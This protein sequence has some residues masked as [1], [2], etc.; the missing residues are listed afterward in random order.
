MLEVTNKHGYFFYF[1]Q[2]FKTS[3]HQVIK[4]LAPHMQFKIHLFIYKNISLQRLLLFFMLLEEASVTVGFD[5]LESILQIL[6]KFIL[7]ILFF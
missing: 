1:P 3:M 5:E 7:K 6:T 2:I 4:F